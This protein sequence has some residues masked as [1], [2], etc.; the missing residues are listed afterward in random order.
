MAR[1]T[2]FRRIPLSPCG[3]FFPAARQTGWVS[4]HCVRKLAWLNAPAAVYGH[5]QPR[6]RCR[7]A[8]G[9]QIALEPVDPVRIF[10]AKS[11]RS[12]EVT[13]GGSWLL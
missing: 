5:R 3:V 13:T 2:E 6:I 1:R 4:P 7:A 9:A 8:A 11:P 10:H 12:D